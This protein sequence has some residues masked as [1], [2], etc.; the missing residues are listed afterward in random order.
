MDGGLEIFTLGGVRILRNGEE[1][2]GINYRKAIALL[3]YLVSTG[4]PQPRVVLADLLWDDRS[5]SQALANLRGVL[6]V[7]RAA[8]GENLRI[9]RDSVSVNPSARVWMDAGQLEAGLSALHNQGKLN[10]FT[11]SQA[12]AALTLYRGDFLQGFNLSDCQGFDDWQRRERE[13]LHQLAADGYT[14]LVSYEIENGQYQLGMVHASR[15]LEIDPLMEVGHRQMMLLLAKCGQ[16]AAAL[17]QYQSCQELMRDE[18]GVDPAE[19]TS[20]LYDQIRNGKLVSTQPVVSISLQNILDT[21][22]DNLPVWLTTFIGREKEIKQVRTLLAASRLVTLTGSGGVGKSRLALEACS[23]LRAGFL[24]GVW[25]VR[26]AQISEERFILPAIA[27]VFNL[28]ETP[29]RSLL[30]VLLDY[31]RQKELLLWIDN[32]EHLVVECARLAEKILNYA[33]QVRI[34]ATSREALGISGETDFYVPSLTLPD[35]GLVQD[36]EALVS[37]EAVRLFLDRATQALPGFR[38]TPETAPAVAQICCQLDGIPLALELAAA[39]VKYLSVSQIAGRLENDFRFL[40]TGSRTASP[41]QQTLQATIDWSYNLL[42]EPERIFLRRLAIFPSGWEL[43]AAEA[44]CSD[45][46]DSLQAGI[47]IQPGNILDLLSRLINKS[48][49]IV[50]REPGLDLHYRLLRTIRQYAG[51][52]LVDA[53]ESERLKTRHLEYFMSWAEIVEVKMQGREQAVWYRRIEKNLENLRSAIR[54]GLD[55]NVQVALRLA[56]T[57]RPFWGGTN[58]RLEGFSWLETC[59]EKSENS[60][61]TQWRGRALCVQADLSQLFVNDRKPIK[62]SQ[63][64]LEICQEIGDLFGQA[65]AHLLLGHYGCAN[66]LNFSDTKAHL[67]AALKLFRENGDRWWEART[68]GAFVEYYENTGDIG[69]A[70]EYNELT[71]KIFRELGDDCRVAI[72]L[73]DQAFI[74]GEHDADLRQ[75]SELYEQALS[76]FH[77]LGQ[78]YNVAYVRGFLAGL[79]IWQ[80]DFAYANELNKNIQEYYTTIA[81]KQQSLRLQELVARCLA[82]QGMYDQAVE[83]L[84]GVLIQFSRIFPTDLADI[85][86]YIAPTITYAYLNLNNTKDVKEFLN[87][88]DGS[89]IISIGGAILLLRVKALL[90]F[91][92]GNVQAASIFF[93]EG[94]EH[95]QKWKYKIGKMLVIEDCSGALLLRGMYPMAVHCLAVA[96]AFRKKIGAKVWPGDLPFL[97]QVQ[98]DLLAELGEEEY[99]RCWKMGEALSLDQA[100]ELALAALNLD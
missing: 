37:Y 14:E 28:R 38:I 19:E 62:W 96:S 31:L 45:V 6:T 18:L 94:L 58:Y 65:Y 47:C 82:F 53:S 59:Q 100:A 10:E 66:F 50:E 36:E 98:R 75:G 32:C 21:K 81:D 55:T 2:R 89:R 80:G 70:K 79:A 60:Q 52:K 64:A 85:K 44:I 49:V 13:R 76:I 42:S 78:D 72:G 23:G 43:E 35:P 57:L 33:P 54:F 91:K 8:L 99:Q 27:A 3:I 92:E 11:A 7:L 87:Q 68:L 63:E 22:L 39:Q 20:E 29:E 5:Q 34:L 84:E 25:L 17:A 83:T 41:R 97:E 15:L 26:L 77:R 67:D 9:Y 74:V 95:A 56:S 90:A 86:D 88:V 61:R 40:N 4:Q 93:R 30:E 71:L 12:E 69:R 48:M 73:T 51:G 46:G 24:H 1:L 16:R